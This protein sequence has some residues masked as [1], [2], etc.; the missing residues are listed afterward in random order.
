MKASEAGAAPDFNRIARLYRWMELFSFGPWLDRCRCAFLGELFDC[1]EGLVL[2]DGDGRFTARLL[3]TNRAIEVEALDASQAMLRE[4]VRRVGPDAGRLRTQCADIRKWQPGQTRYDLVVSHFF[5]D[6]LTTD[7][8]RALAAKAGNAVADSAL[9][10]VSEFA[11][12][13]GWF[14]RWVAR[15]VVGGLYCAFG[16]ITGLRIRALPQYREVF[17]RCG[18]RLERRRVW[19]GGLL[20]SEAWR[21]GDLRKG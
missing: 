12:P 15:P 1:R 16:G 11:V 19:L 20:V 2:G 7:E 8:V 18:F 14:G 6:C 9:W 17:E 3:G 10:V 21:T 4:L 5:L 13:E